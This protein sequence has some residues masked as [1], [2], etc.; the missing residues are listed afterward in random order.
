MLYITPDSMGFFC[1]FFMLHCDRIWYLTIFLRL[2]LF[3]YR[4]DHEIYV[5]VH[6]VPVVSP[7]EAV[8]AHIE[9]AKFHIVAV[10]AH[11]VAATAHIETVT[12]H[13]EASKALIEDVSVHIEVS[14]SHMSAA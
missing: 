7:I 3:L 12:V 13:T 8:T 10:I 6:T 4:A 2:C 1:S 11:I 9:D 14:T 5:T